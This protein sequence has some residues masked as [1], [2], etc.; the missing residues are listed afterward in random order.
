MAEAAPLLPGGGHSQVSGD[1]KYHCA[2]CMVLRIIAS[3]TNIVT[4]LASRIEYKE[5]EKS[6]LCWPTETFFRRQSRAALR[7]PKF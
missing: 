5:R 4:Y 1:I 7:G 3:F 2:R 6:F